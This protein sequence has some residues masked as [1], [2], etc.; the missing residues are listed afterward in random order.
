MNIL[1]RALL[2]VSGAIWGSAMAGPIS[3]PD[4]PVYFDYRT[5]EQYSPSNAINTP[6]NPAASGVTEG[7]WGIVQVDSIS[8]GKALTPQGWQIDSLGPPLFSNGQGAQ[9]LGIFYGVHNNLHS[10][11]TPTTS[12]GG[13]LDLYHWD[14]NSQD[15]GSELGLASNLSKRSGPGGS[16]YSGFTCQTN[17]ANCSFLVRLRFSPGADLNSQINT[18]YSPTNSLNFEAYFSVDTTLHGYW[19]DQFNSNYFTLNPNKD[20]CGDPTISCISANDVRADGQVLQT[21]GMGWNVDPDI[22][23]LRKVGALRVFDVPEPGSL[24]LT[25]LALAALGYARIRRLRFRRRRI[26]GFTQRA[27]LPQAWI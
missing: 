2:A 18:I 25:T 5:A 3:L 16:Q 8:V 27:C 24:A 22:V 10:P 23:S 12:T 4:G 7:N 15:V 21:G 13:T 9:I 14:S 6:N 20:Q 11:G 19:T 26:T 17:T 1:A